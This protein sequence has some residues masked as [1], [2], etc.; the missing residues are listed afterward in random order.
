MIEHKKVW[1][2][3]GYELFAL[4]GPGALKVETISKK[5]GISKSSFYHHFSDLSLFIEQLLE[6]HLEQAHI[7]AAKEQSSK[8][9]DPELIVVLQEHKMDLLFSRQLRIHRNEQQFY[10][11][12][13]KSNR[14]VGSAFV[15]LWARELN[16]KLN[17]GQL[18]ALFELALE[19]FFLQITYENLHYD[20]LSGYFNNL[21]RIAHHFN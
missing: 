9:I 17:P 7:M 1:I 13:T 2:K 16:L 18:E 6:H 5:M 10:D 21:K 12:L 8:N 15:Y 3:T 19:N 14:I 4:S 11:A 20:W